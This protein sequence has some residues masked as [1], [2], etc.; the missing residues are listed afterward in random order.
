MSAFIGSRDSTRREF[1]GSVS[2]MMVA[3]SAISIPTSSDRIRESAAKQ[4]RPGRVVT[5]DAK[6]S[7]ITFDTAKA[8]VIVC[9]MQNDFG[10]EGG[11]FQRA[12]IDIS[13]IQRAVPPTARVLAA[14]R[15]AG[16]PCIYLKM[17]FRPD[18]S[19]AGS[20]DSPNRI[21]HLPFSVGKTVRAPNGTESRVLIRDTWNTDIVSELT[22]RPEDIVLY[23]FRYSGFYETELDVILKGLGITH[24]IVTGCTTSVCVESTIRDA[25][26]RDYSPI[27]LAD[28][29]AEPIGYDLPR[30]NHE[31]SL[32]TIQTLLGWVSSSAAFTKALS[33]APS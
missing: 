25:M 26:Y 5:I 29:S 30:S 20:I 6:P 23:K 17:A 31:A 12:G 22:P 11:M 13:M 18:L 4:R 9:D 32:L 8:G 24:L 1:L 33:V 10:S 19:D 16:I 15:S 21:K 28:C 2:L 3:G 7:P 14:A 27:L